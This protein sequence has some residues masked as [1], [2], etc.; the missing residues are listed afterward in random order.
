[1][2]DLLRG[3][4]V[5]TIHSLLSS[6][7]GLR[8]HRGRV[9]LNSVRPAFKF[10]KPAYV[11][12]QGSSS[13]QDDRGICATIADDSDI[14]PR[15][16]GPLIS[17][18]G[19]KSQWKTVASAIAEKQGE[20]TAL[21][22]RWPLSL[23]E[24]TEIKGLSNPAQLRKMPLIQKLLHGGEANFHAALSHFFGPLSAAEQEIQRALIKGATEVRP[25]VV[26]RA[27]A[28]PQDIDKVV[29]WALQS[30][31]AHALTGAAMILLMY[32]AF[33]RVSELCDLRLDDITFKGGS[34]WWLRIKKSKVDQQGAGTRIA[35]H[36]KGRQ[37]LLW[38]S[39]TRLC[40]SRP[41]ERYLFSSSHREAPSRDFIDRT[42]K[43][44]LQQAGLGSRHLTTHS[45]RGGAATA[46]IRAG[47]APQ[48]VMRV[49]RWKTQ[50]AFLAYVEP[51]PL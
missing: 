26:H 14:T 11:R 44:A 23:E 46:A 28:V 30:D 22:F 37:L 25:P 1:M 17:G 51:T 2:E 4:R 6:P 32:V 27:K 33:L 12:I 47:I 41:R 34:V 35:F 20:D 8:E 48:N 45:F 42:V 19:V 50:K 29:N 3:D 16:A 36:L 24:R 5:I 21:S 49:G 7:F 39:F 9:L 38:E 10:V 40:L 31:S 18:E 43:H 13:S 15:T